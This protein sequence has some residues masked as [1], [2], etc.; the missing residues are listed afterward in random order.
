MNMLLILFAMA[1]ICYVS[2][3]FLIALVPLVIVFV[4]LNA[5][6]TS[7]VRELKRLDATT[8]SPVLSHVTASVQ[9]ISTIH[10]YGKSDEFVHK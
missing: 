1:T 9:G 2:P 8:R 10:A 3:W 4:L 6:F 7:G 5:L